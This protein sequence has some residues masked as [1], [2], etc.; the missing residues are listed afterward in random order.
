[1]V[2]NRY[3]AFGITL[4]FAEIQRD[5]SVATLLLLLL[6]LD[7]EAETWYSLLDQVRQSQAAA[8]ESGSQ[9]CM[10]HL[11]LNIYL[12]GH[13]FIHFASVQ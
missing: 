12:F 11:T 13:S 4:P 8:D 1:M 5:L 10:L 6:L 7:A 2:D 3:C 9:Q